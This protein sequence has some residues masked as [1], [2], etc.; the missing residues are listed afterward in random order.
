[1]NVLYIKPSIKS[2]SA[3]DIIEQLGPCQ[4]QYTTSNMT[5]DADDWIF[6]EGDEY[7]LGSVEDPLYPVRIGYTHPGEEDESDRGFFSF[8]ISSIHST[9]VS[10]TLKIY[11]VS[12]GGFQTQGT[13]YSDSVLG[14]LLVDHV[15]CGTLEANATDFDNNDV[16]RSIDSTDDSADNNWKEFDVKNAVQADIDVGRSTSQFRVRFTID[17]VGSEEDNYI[18]IE[19]K[20]YH[21]GT[22]NKAQLVVTYY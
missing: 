12:A 20:D 6:K 14:N 7:F 19:D 5:L 15:N 10:A 11:Q 8:D 22:S 13:P 16:T 17:T 9:V 1:M 2:Y 3:G 4:N 21:G 18:Y